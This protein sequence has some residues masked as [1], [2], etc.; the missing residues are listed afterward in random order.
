MNFKQTMRQVLGLEGEG[1]EA[2]IYP[3]SNIP[4]DNYEAMCTDVTQAVDVIAQAGAERREK[5]YVEIADRAGDV[6]E[7]LV[8]LSPLIGSQ[9]PVTQ[10]FATIATEHALA[11]IGYND[12][13]QSVGCEGFSTS[14]LD[15]I[16]LN[17]DRVFPKVN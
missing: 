7:A 14:R 16:V 3:E 10:V 8:E 1:N 12:L 17:I 6:K 15:E 5:D 9:D 2:P 11:S 4:N 13:G